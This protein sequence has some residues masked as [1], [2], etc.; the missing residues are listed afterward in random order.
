MYFR[1]VGTVGSWPSQIVRR[2][3]PGPPTTETVTGPALAPN[4]EHFP[5]DGLG[6]KHRRAPALQIRGVSRIPS[7]RRE[8]NAGVAV[9]KSLPVFDA[10]GP[11][12]APSIAP[13]LTAETRGRLFFPF[14]SH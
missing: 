4:G 10:D 7:R 2:T 8:E 5:G 3:T 1:F 11:C 6:K 9:G 14:F 13:C 12:E